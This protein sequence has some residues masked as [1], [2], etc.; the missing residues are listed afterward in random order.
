MNSSS[1]KISTK[2][3]TGNGESRKVSDMSLF[4]LLLTP[5]APPRMG[6]HCRIKGLSA[7]SRVIY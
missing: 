7:K 5:T 4:S 3:I 2:D 6:I 1:V